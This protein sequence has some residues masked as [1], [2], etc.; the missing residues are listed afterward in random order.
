MPSEITDSEIRAII[1]KYNGGATLR[2]LG[3]RYSVSRMRIKRMLESHNVPMRQP[4]RRQITSLSERKCWK[5]KTVKEIAKFMRSKRQ[6]SGYD[7]T[8]KSCRKQWNRENSLK[9]TYGITVELYAAMV[10][11]QGGHCAICGQPES[12]FRGSCAIEL[13][14]DHCHNSGLVRGLL[15]GRCNTALGLM[16]DDVQVLQKAIDYLSK[17]ENLEVASN[18]P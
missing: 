15:C 14:V 3:E 8:C 7:Y 9:K 16:R 10:A 17:F 18:I 5:C 1:A 4:G 2:Q 11:E 6:P 13:A 12:R